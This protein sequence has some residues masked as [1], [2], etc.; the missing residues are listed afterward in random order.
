MLFFISSVSA[1]PLPCAVCAIAIASGL[2]IARNLGVSETALGVW[3]GAF[4]FVLSRWTIS[5]L[6]KKNIKK[7]W[8]KVLTYLI[9]YGG[10]IFP[11]YLKDKPRYEFLGAIAIGTGILIG[12]LKLYS[13]IKEKNGKPHF[14]FEKVVLPVVSL[15]L[16][17][18]L[19]N[20]FW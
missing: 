15:I 17:S 12:T 6:E 18:I 9:W 3:I 14:P 8:V 4:L 7:Q 19:F 13:H 2:G 10:S 5:W 16:I 11:L 1:A 20:Y